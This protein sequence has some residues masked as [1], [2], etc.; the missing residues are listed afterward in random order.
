MDEMDGCFYWFGCLFLCVFFF[1]GGG[2]IVICEIFFL[3]CE[4]YWKMSFIFSVFSVW[5]WEILIFIELSNVEFGIFS[6]LCFFYSNLEW[7]IKLYELN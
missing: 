5:I 3:V 6:I 7:V 4:I 2:E 1:F